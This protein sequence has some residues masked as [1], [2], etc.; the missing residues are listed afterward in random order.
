MTTR[1][2]LERTL[3]R[4]IGAID[5]LEVATVGPFRV[6]VRARPKAGSFDELKEQIRRALDDDGMMGVLYDI[7]PYTDRAA[8]A[9]AAP[10][11]VQLASLA[12]DQTVAGLKETLVKAVPALGRARFE[13]K[14][15]ESVRVLVAHEDGS[16]NDALVKKVQVAIDAVGYA[17]LAFN[18]E[19]LPAN[20]PR[21]DLANAG[22]FLPRRDSD[23]VRLTEEDEE[24]YATRIRK[25][26]EGEF[27]EIALL[28]EARGAKLLA[29]PALKPPL[30]LPCL[31]PFYDIVFVQMP[32]WST[33]GSG[34]FEHHFGATRSDFLVYC[35]RGRVVPIFKFNLGIYP[36]D[37]VE[38]WLTNLSLPWLTPRTFDYIALRHVWK[39]SPHLRLLREDA[40]AARVLAGA[41]NTALTARSAD[42]RGAAQFLSW[43]LHGSEYFEGVA[44]HRGHLALANLSSG[45]PV[46]HIIAG[47]PG[48]FPSKAAAQ[49]VSIEAFGAITSIAAAQAFDASLTEGMLLNEGVLHL[50]LP[51]FRDSRKVMAPTGTTA[52]KSI[53]ETLNLDYSGR[54]PAQEYLDVLDLSE[55]R[56]IREISQ[57]LLGGEVPDGTTL[58]LRERVR[59]LNDEVRKIERNAIESAGVD[60]VG[61]LA[62][63]GSNAQALTGVSPVTLGFKLIA[64][65][66][67]L[68]LV[69]RIGGMAFERVI[70]D[71]KA[72][73]VLDKVRGAVNGVSP[74]AIRI[75]RLR[76]KLVGR[77]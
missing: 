6:Q 49:T 15:G 8:T 11:P 2:S 52:L 67:Q 14:P 16:S 56:R 28:D 35:Q 4:R 42:A 51:Y 29:T 75:Y 26:V 73:D 45:G 47:A 69:K 36:R 62:K 18:V 77:G 9:S 65:L 64:D 48:L 39:T 3:R 54:I 24:R 38:P 43:L 55:T 27:E 25:L 46:G 37:V 58:E 31:L 17:G 12:A 57:L 20:E 72:G 32:S 30:P 21:N 7:V 34:Y 13:E 19:Q 76:R 59:K 23:I 53:I 40:E 33:D 44:W 68:S 10:G 74:E 70:D 66:L 71:T 50:V 63:S 61:D 22:F 5:A 60:V 1:A 41:V